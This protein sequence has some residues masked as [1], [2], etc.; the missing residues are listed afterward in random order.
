MSG[1]MDDPE[2]QAARVFVG[3]VAPDTE[4]QLLIE[5]FSKYGNV[6]GTVVD[7]LL[8]GSLYTNTNKDE[9]LL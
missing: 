6:K 4:E 5:R 8:A 1:R 7:K 3:G 9:T 2:N